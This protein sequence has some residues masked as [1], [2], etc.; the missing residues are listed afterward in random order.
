MIRRRTLT[1]L[2]GVLV[3]LWLGL[4]YCS[5]P[6][7]AHEYQRTAVN[8]ADATL[9]AV[10]TV[11]LAGTE[12]DRL[13]A[14]TFDVLVDDEA[15]AVA[16]AQQRLTAEQPPDDGTRRLRD[17]LLPLLVS[18]GREIADLPDAADPAPHLDRLRDLGDRLDTFVESNR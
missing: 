6:P 14:P 16:S 7:D 12:R 18:A 15:G 5:G 17:Q 9:S 11:A 4:A 1:A 10:R 8:A 2:A 3:L 13:L